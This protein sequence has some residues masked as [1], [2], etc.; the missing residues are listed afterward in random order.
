MKMHAAWIGEDWWVFRKS[1]PLRPEP[2]VQWA[3]PFYTQER[4]EQWK[5][6]Q[7]WPANMDMM[8]GRRAIVTMPNDKLSDSHE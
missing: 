4:A 3:G 2:W 7:L 8:V 1:D 5:S 6:L